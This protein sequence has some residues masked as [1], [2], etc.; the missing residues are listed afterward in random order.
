[1]LSVDVFAT[2]IAL[3]VCLLFAHRVKDQ[4]QLNLLDERL[5]AFLQ[6]T[7][8]LQ[9]SPQFHVLLHFQPTTE[10]FKAGRIV[11]H[12]ESGLLTSGQGRRHHSQIAVIPSNRTSD[13]YRVNA[14][15]K[16]VPRQRVPR[17]VHAANENSEGL[18]GW[19]QR[20][21]VSPGAVP[22]RKESARRFDY[23][24]KV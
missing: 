11:S 2:D 10:D 20:P 13:R 6:L 19:R 15:N 1:L 18:E 21:H 9:F 3:V 14:R 8:L 22:P 12:K 16:K 24:F 4:M 7:R 23:L 5:K 17:W